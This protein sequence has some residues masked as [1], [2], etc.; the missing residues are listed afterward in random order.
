MNEVA[1]IPMVPAVQSIES[2]VQAAE[3]LGKAFAMSGLFGCSKVEQGI[4]LAMHCLME[5]KSPLEIM[6]EYHIVEGKLSMKADAML[7]KLSVNGGQ[8]KWVKT[9]EDGKEAHL[10]IKYKEREDTVPFTMAD[11][12]KQGIVK[13][14]SAWQKTPGAMLRARCT[15]K[16]MRMLAPELVSG[17]Y[18]PEEVQDF[19]NK[20]DTQPSK[21]LL[22]TV[23]PV[24]ESVK[25]V[26]ECEPA[27]IPPRTEKHDLVSYFC[28]AILGYEELAKKWF[29]KHAWIKEGQSCTDVSEAKM[30]QVIDKKDSFIAKIQE[31]V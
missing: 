16:A 31:K 20:P 5:R 21:P 27:P 6:A 25:V 19:D 24:D 14:G 22:A 8:F 9:G 4:V 3:V 12:I 7:A 30:K 28:Q 17:T 23:S 13:S 15:S 18:V 29:V 10:W 1:T 26:V 11:A 2:M